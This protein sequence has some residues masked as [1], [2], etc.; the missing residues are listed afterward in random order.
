MVLTCVQKKQFSIWIEHIHVC[1]T[2]EDI[3]TFLNLVNREH[4]IEL[5]TE[6]KG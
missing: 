4:S 1:E 5:I 6:M 3:S 2:E